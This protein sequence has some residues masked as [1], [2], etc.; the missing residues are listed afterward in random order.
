MTKEQFRHF[1]LIGL[2]SSFGFRRRTSIRKTKLAGLD[3][4]R[5]QRL[6]LIDLEE[7]LDLELSPET[8]YEHP[9]VDNLSDISPASMRHVRVDLTPMSFSS[10]VELL[11]HRAVTQPDDGAFVFVRPWS[12]GS[13][14]DFR[15]AL[16]PCRRAGAELLEGKARRPRVANFPSGPRLHCGAVRMFNGGRHRC[17]NDGAAPPEL[18]R[19]TAIITTDCAPRFILAS[20]LLMSWPRKDVAARFADGSYEW[21]AVDAMVDHSPGSDSRAVCRRFEAR[22]SRS[23]DIRPAPPPI[24]N[25]V[26]VTHEKLLQNLEMM[27]RAFCA[28]RASTFV[29]W[30]LLYHD[31]GFILSAL[32]AFYVGACCALMA[33]PHRAAA[34]GSG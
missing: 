34:N 28:T 13:R 23:P 15:A 22:L 2:P 30:I 8:F 17:S 27:P 33:P 6:L 16:R 11:E 21:I 1:A 3:F 14:A 26:V 32:E 29:S 20:P 9:T 19:F 25:R 31:M 10:L 18:T 4:D 5:P 7:K 12:A 24:R